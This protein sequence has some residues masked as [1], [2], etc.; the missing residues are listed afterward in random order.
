M[1]WNSAKRECIECG[2]QIANEG[3]TSDLAK[4][5]QKLIDE[6][7]PSVWLYDC[8]TVENTGT[9]S[10]VNCDSTFDAV[11]CILRGKFSKLELF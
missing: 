10:Q 2:G 3:D 1:N 11:F 7:L 6:N 4:M 8:K 5:K 9:V